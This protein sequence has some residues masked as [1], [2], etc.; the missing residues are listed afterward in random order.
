MT[1]H[2]LGS[3]STVIG[4]FVFRVYCHAGIDRR[5]VEQ[6]FH[7]SFPHRQEVR[8]RRDC[9]IVTKSRANVAIKSSN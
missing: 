8:R 5:C 1:S 3:N 7:F 2:S 6:Q 9:I 4:E